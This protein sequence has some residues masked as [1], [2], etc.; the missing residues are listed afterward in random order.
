MMARASSLRAEQKRRVKNAA[1]VIL[2]AKQKKKAS[3]ER[4]A[5]YREKFACSGSRLIKLQK[6]EDECF[7]IGFVGENRAGRAQALKAVEA[8]LKRATELKVRGFE[9]SL[10]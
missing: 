3:R 2:T 6:E 4:R 5:S 7:Y 9:Y 10:D 1:P 8:F